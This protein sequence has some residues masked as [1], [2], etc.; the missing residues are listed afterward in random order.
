MK[1][2]ISLLIITILFIYNDIH[3]QYYSELIQLH[4]G[5]KS[6]HVYDLTYYEGNKYTIQA[7]PGQ[8]YTGK[9]YFNDEL[10][11]DFLDE[12]E[13]V[14][15]AAGRRL[16]VKMNTTN[17]YL[18]HTLVACPDQGIHDVKFIDGQIYCKTYG[19]EGFQILKYTNSSEID[20]LFE[21]PENQSI[22]IDDFIVKNNKLLVVGQF[23]RSTPY[24]HYQQDTLWHGVEDAGSSSAYVYSIDLINNSIDYSLSYGGIYWYVI[25]DGVQLDNNGNAYIWGDHASAFSIQGDTSDYK[26]FGNGYTDAHLIRL[27]P[28]GTLIKLHSFSSTS[29]A[30]KINSFWLGNDGAYYAIFE[31]RGGAATYIDK[32]KDY[33]KMAPYFVYSTVY[34]FDTSGN[35]LWSFPLK[36]S[37]GIGNNLYGESSEHI[38]ACV[39]LGSD[40]LPLMVGESAQHIEDPQMSESHVFHYKI[41]KTTGELDGISKPIRNQ[42][43][44]RYTAGTIAGDINTLVLEF[45]NSDVVIDSVSYPQYSDSYSIKALVN[46]DFTVNT[47]N[48]GQAKELVIYPTLLNSES[49]INVLTD[50][51][52]DIDYKL[53]GL[54]GMLIL[55]GRLKDKM[56]NLENLKLTDGIYY[57]RFEQ[58]M[59]TTTKA[60][61]IGR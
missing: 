26:G 11:I 34:K 33:D 37:R 47:E 6:I 52:G 46:I 59:E 24:I 7:I 29:D 22:I 40:P 27:A 48:L 38:Y 23:N 15:T 39:H 45:Y 41:D 28:D 61:Y 13:A 50:F 20:T 49:H 58:D 35:V 51:E 4:N 16:L 60:I 30:D 5:E 18:D 32:E 44:V 36:T 17:D 42:K 57:L 56:I 21:F 55:S 25:S 10:K 3:G 19:E 2:I 14:P 31:S 53:F 9:V 43:G 54:D 8:N 12:L 1:P